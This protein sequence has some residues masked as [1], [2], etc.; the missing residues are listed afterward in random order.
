[1]IEQVREGSQIIFELATKSISQFIDQLILNMVNN[2]VKIINN[3]IRYTMSKTVEQLMSVTQKKTYSTLL[4]H[5]VI[6]ILFLI[7]PIVV[8]TRPSG[9]PFLTITRPFIRDVIGSSLLVAFFY[10][11]YYYLIP[12]FYIPQRFIR[13]AFW[14]IFAL[15]T[16]LV[17]PSLVTG[18]FHERISG[19][20]VNL[21]YYQ[22][23]PEI[24]EITFGNFLLNELR[25]HL[26]LFVIVLFFAVLLRKREYLSSIKE[27]KLQAELL[28][29]KSQI[30]PHFLFN[31]LNSIYTLSVIKDDRASDA[32]ISLSELMRYVIK[33]S[34]N[35]KIPLQKEVSYIKNYVALQ[36]ARLGNTARVDLKYSGD[37]GNMEISPLILIT[38]I[39]NAFKYGINPDVEGSL[40]D[41]A[42]EVT[43]NG[44]MLRTYNIKVLALS[45]PGSVSSF[46]Q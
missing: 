23:Q 46:F 25:H 40:V 29:L 2:P 5:G 42:L 31:T 16:V 36:Q 20:P 14:V 24:P 32:I 45:H 38:Y 44:V 7:I 3:K 11:S 26:Y 27:E 9:E 10:F 1:M 12:S 15:F 6:C 33:D 13:F 17:L 18:R 30:N 34:Q 41:I 35:Y 8:S 19:P 37:P 21:Q 39:E 4:F 28:S 22:K 43:G